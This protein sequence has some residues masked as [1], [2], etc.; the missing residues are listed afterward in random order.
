M[1]ILLQTQQLTP[2]HTSKNIPEFTNTH[3]PKNM[4]VLLWVG[5]SLLINMCHPLIKQ[6]AAIP[7]FVVVR[8]W[9]QFF[10]MVLISC[11]F[12]NGCKTCCVL[13]GS[14][15]NPS[16][17]GSR[18]PSL[19]PSVWWRRSGAGPVRPRALGIP[20]LSPAKA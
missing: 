11:F 6:H 15:S 19:D 18:S 4:A 12:C 8:I 10:L 5:P 7:H 2:C 9:L 3:I 16:H 14:M 13:K 1:Q 20:L 17:I